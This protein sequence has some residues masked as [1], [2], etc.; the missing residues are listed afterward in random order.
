MINRN[1]TTKFIIIISLISLLTIN[2]D[3]KKRKPP[4]SRFEKINEQK[5]C[6]DVIYTKY[7][8]KNGRLNHHI[9]LVTAN[10]ENKDI[11][12]E[13]LLSLDRTGELEKLSNTVNN[14]QFNNSNKILAAI[15][16]NFWRAYSYLPIGPT[17]VNG[18]IAEMIT[19]KQWSSALFD[20]NNRL[21]IDNFYITGKITAN[22]NRFFDIVTV[23]RRRD[24]SGMVLYNKFY[25]SSVP[26]IKEKSIEA[27]Y[28]KMQYE[29]LIFNDSTELE[30]DPEQMRFEL[31]QEKIISSIEFK[32]VKIVL[33]YIDPPAV[34]RP[35]RCRVITIKTGS[36]DI[37]YNGCIISVGQDIPIEVLPN[38]NDIITI[39]LT[40]NV[41]TKS[42]FINGV[43]GTPRLVRNGIAKHEAYQEGSQGRR[44]INRMLPRTAIGTDKKGSKIFLVYIEPSRTKNSAGANLSQLAIIMKRLGAYNAM[45]LDGG[46]SSVMVINNGELVRVSPNE[47]RRISVGLAI[48]KY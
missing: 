31:M 9:H 45:N 30:F 28:A 17:I 25:G 11:K 7:I 39:T 38:T 21:I 34:N 33:E 41:H 12:P 36:V 44:F 26:F 27:E 40:T 8:F 29:R 43:S 15:N 46:G 5:L 6:D 20:E 37:P 18:E 47:G 32:L 14:Y 13:V 35:Y 3:A 48:S 23:N 22:R 42:V 16:A 19:H 10:L 24:S 1:C 4:V 2:L